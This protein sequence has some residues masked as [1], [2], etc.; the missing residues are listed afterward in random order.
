VEAQTKIAHSLKEVAAYEFKPIL[1]RKGIKKDLIVGLI[2]ERGGGKSGSGAVISLI[3]YMMSGW[4]CYSNMKIALDLV[5]DDEIARKYGLEKGGTVSYRSLPVIMPK[6]LRFDEMYR[7]SLIFLD[8]IN[9]E[10]ADARRAM[11]NTNLFSN[12]LAQE[13]RHLESSII[14]TCISEMAIDPRW[15]DIVDAFIRSEETAYYEENI[16]VG[17]PLG[18]DFH[19]SVYFMNRC[20]N[21]HTYDETHKPAFEGMFHFKPWRGTYNDKE[22][23]GEGMTKYGVNF[24]D[25]DAELKGELT[26]TDG[27]VVKQYRDE[28]SWFEPIAQ[29]LLSRNDKYIPCSEVM[30]EEEIRRRKLTQAQVTQHLKNYFNI[31][32]AAKTLDGQRLTCYVLPEMAYSD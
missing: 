4:P 29:D 8:E 19:W 25:Y 27:P 10:I 3:D 14:F 6:L 2:G 24:K 20:F 28:W 17:K 12:K 22:F 26:I 15:R 9:V 30:A 23:Q 32:S 21:G 7:G 16:R 18:I 31:Y 11:S 1:R 5:I 13:L